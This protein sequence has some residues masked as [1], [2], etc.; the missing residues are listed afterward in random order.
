MLTCLYFTGT[1]RA[2]R[3]G[4]ALAAMRACPR[5]TLGKREPGQVFASTEHTCVTVCPTAGKPCGSYKHTL[6]NGRRTV[7]RAVKLEKF[8][9]SLAKVRETRTGGMARLGNK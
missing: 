8:Q 2:A 6:T 9:N 4:Q 5:P 3:R 7:S 1:C